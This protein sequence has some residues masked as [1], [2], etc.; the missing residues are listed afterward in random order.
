[1][2]AAELHRALAVMAGRLL[3]SLGPQRCS[4]TASSSSSATGGSGGTAGSLTGS[5][6]IATGGAGRERNC[7]EY[8]S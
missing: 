5:A 3:Q 2:V 1:M 8:C 7:R 6:G 4:G